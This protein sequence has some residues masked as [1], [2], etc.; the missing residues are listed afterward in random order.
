MKIL[1]QD[2]LADIVQQAANE[3]IIG[4]F[5]FRKLGNIFTGYGHSKGVFPELGYIKIHQGHA[6][7]KQ[8]DNRKRN[9]GVSNC[10]IAQKDNCIAQVA[11]FGFK[12][13]KSRI[14]QL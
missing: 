13:I 12:S 8:I 7:R 6:F 4:G 5:L 1:G 2:D 10:I 14:H 11:N 3:A 9:N